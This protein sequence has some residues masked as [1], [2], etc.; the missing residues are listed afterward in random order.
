MTTL[1]TS[2]LFTPMPNAVVAT[3]IRTAPLLKSSCTLRFCVADR[4][5]AFAAFPL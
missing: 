3:T 5:P 1:R 2:C 4:L